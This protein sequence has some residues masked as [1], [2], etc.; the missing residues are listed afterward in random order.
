MAEAAD[1]PARAFACCQTCFACAAEV[2]GVAHRVRRPDLR[3]GRA[4]K[5]W[6]L[7]DYRAGDPPRVID[8]KATARAGRLISRDFAQDDRLQIVIVDRCRA[9][10]RL[11]CR[12]AR[13]LRTLCE[14]RRAAGADRRR[15]G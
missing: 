3:P 2:K 15:T 4:P 13:S 12:S 8:W 14:R 7:R 11:A 1:L 10:Q 6:R 9:R 5:C